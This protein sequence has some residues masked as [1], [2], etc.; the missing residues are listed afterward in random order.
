MIARLEIERAWL[1]PASHFHIGGL[2]ATFR[3]GVIQEIRD[4]Q[5]DLIELGLH[6]RELRFRS[7]QFLTERFHLLQ[8]RSNVLSLRFCLPHR[9]RVNVTFVTQL[10]DAQL[11]LATRLLERAQPLDIELEP[12]AGQVGSNGGRIGTQQLGIEHGER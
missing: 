1:A 2:V 11:P 9:L 10:I 4:A 5:R 8:Q 12:A 6:F 7:G 3:H